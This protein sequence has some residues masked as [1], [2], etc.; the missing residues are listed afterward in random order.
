MIANLWK[1]SKAKQNHTSSADENKSAW[2][3]NRKS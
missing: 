2:V 1:E 3:S